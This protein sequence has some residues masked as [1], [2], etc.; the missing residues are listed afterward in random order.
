VETESKEEE[1]VVKV[2]PLTDASFLSKLSTEV[3]KLLH[4]IESFDKKSL[5]GPTNLDNKWREVLDVQNTES[6][7]RSI[8]VARC[9]PMKNR[10]PDI[11]PFD[12]SRVSIPSS[13]DDYIN[14]SV[15]GKLS[16]GAVPFIITQLPLPATYGDFWH[17]VF[18]QGVEL[19]VSLLGDQELD[20]LGH[21]YYPTTRE[22]ELLLPPFRVTLQ[23][24]NKRQGHVQRIFTLQQ[25]Q[26]KL[27]RVVIQL[28]FNDWGPGA[29][30]STPASLLAFLAEVHSFYDQQ[31][32]HQSP[33]VLHCLAGVGRSGIFVILSAA[34]KEITHGNTIIDLTMVGS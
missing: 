14:A 16:A 18:D 28:Q 2:D 17:M 23:S 32:K 34:I 1:K 15:L 6:G 3:E 20:Q 10:F 21:V 29:F 30:P 8:S 25:M 27:S 24:L 7:K 11:L 5:N 26:K 22:Q 19:I 33:V 12:Q 31:R 13:K 9:Y 4:T